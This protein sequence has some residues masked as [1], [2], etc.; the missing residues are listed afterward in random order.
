MVLKIR[1]I[2]F[3]FFALFTFSTATMAAPPSWIQV[4]QQQVLSTVSGISQF[5]ALGNSTVIAIGLNQIFQ[6]TD[7]G[8][9]WQIISAPS[10]I[11]STEILTSVSGYIGQHGDV[12]V[13]GYQ[14]LYK[15]NVLS[16]GAVRWDLIY[17]AA[18]IV[19]LAQFPYDATALP[20]QL[21]AALHL[22]PP[23]TAGNAPAIQFS[24]D[25]VN[26]KASS[27]YPLMT[28]PDYTTAIV[29]HGNDI[30]A[31]SRDFGVYAS[32]DGGN[33]FSYVG[34]RGE[35]CTSV[36][37]SQ[38]PTDGY[39]HVAATD[40]VGLFRAPFENAQFVRIGPPDTLTPQEHTTVIAFGPL[41][42]AA[43]SLSTSGVWY[44]TSCGDTGSWQALST[45]FP[46][47]FSQVTS[48]GSV[49]TYLLASVEIPAVN[50][51]VVSTYR[52]DLSS[53]IPAPPNLSPPGPPG[54]LRVIQN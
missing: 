17:T 34:L 54:N 8:M 7:S 25:G 18:S 29:V 16:S 27:G 37:I 21:V 5:A 30:T 39:Y 15:R 10:S 50:S 33:N 23:A 53:L 38:H 4:D 52:I 42:V 11:P 26:W 13:G 19:A 2:C 40:Q 1:L 20:Q 46:A 36:A 28:A 51:P 14:G 32:H 12:Y 35:L 24:A 45:G 41:L 22:F 44:S 43:F 47:R 49:G 6:S 31:G 9:T 3:V 48:F